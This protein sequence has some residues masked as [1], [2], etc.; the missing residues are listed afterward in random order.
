MSRRSACALC[1]RSRTEAPD[2][3]VGLP[4]SNAAPAL[5]VVLDALA[6]QGI[7]PCQRCLD[8]ILTALRD[9]G[10][11]A[12]LSYAATAAAAARARLSIAPRDPS[13]KRR[14]KLKQ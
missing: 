11:L 3:A 6:D 9:R 13:R 5:V 12:A 14:K 10:P 7:A 2:A 8:R 1:M 4:P